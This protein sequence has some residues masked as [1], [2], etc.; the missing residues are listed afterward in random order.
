MLADDNDLA[1]N[2]EDKNILIAQAFGITDVDIITTVPTDINLEVV[3]DDDAGKF[4]LILAAISQMNENAGDTVSADSTSII[5]ALYADM[6]DGSIEGIDGVDLITA[7]N[8]FKNGTGANNE[9]DGTGANNTGGAESS[10]GEGSIMGDLAITKIDAYDG[11][12]SVPTVEDYINANVTGVADSNLL[13]INAHMI[14][15]DVSTTAK[16]QIRAD[17]GISTIDA[18]IAKISNY[19]G[20]NDT[21][22]LQDY[23]DASVSKVSETNIEHI[24]SEFAFLP[25]ADTNTTAKIQLIINDI[26]NA[27]FVIDTIANVSIAENT[28]FT[29]IAPTTS[30]DKPIGLLTY[31]LTGDDA[32]FVTIDALTGIVSMAGRNFEHP[33]DINEDNIYEF[34]I[35]LTDVEGNTASERQTITVTNLD[36]S[37]SFK[38]NSIANIPIAE[39][40]QFSGSTPSIAG[41]FIGSIVYSLSG[42]DAALFTINTE[43][44]VIAMTA[45]DFETPMDANKDNNYEVLII[46]IDL[47]GNTDS[48]EQIIT[49]LNAD[50]DH[51]AINPIDNVIIAENEVF[52][53]LAPSLISTYSSIGFETYSLS[54]VDMADFTIKPLTGIVSMVGRNFEEPGDDNQDNVYEIV[55]VVTDSEDNT[56]S[57]SQTITVTDVVETANFTVNPIDNATVA[58]NATFTGISPSISGVYIGRVNYSLVGVD[59]GAFTIDSTTGIVTMDV[60][61]FENPKDANADNVYQISIVATDVDGNTDDED[62]TITVTDVIEQAVFSMLPIADDSLT[63]NYQFN[64]ERPFLTGDTPIGDIVYSLGGEDADDFTIDTTTGMITM[65]TMDF[66]NP[67]DFDTDNIYKVIIIATDEDGNIASESQLITITNFNENTIV[68]DN[69]NF[70]IDENS[71][72]DTVVGT[73]QTTGEPTSFSI[74]ED[75][76]GGVFAID[77]NGLIT[78]V[79]SSKINYENNIYFALKVEITKIDADSKIADIGINVLDLIEI[80]NFNIDTIA[81]VIIPAEANFTG[82]VP[83]LSGDTPIGVLNYTLEGADAT[84]FIIDPLSGVVSKIAPDF[85]NPTDANNNNVYEITITLTD[86]DG[87]TYSENQ[88]IEITLSSVNIGTQTWSNHNIRAI[89][90]TS[91]TLNIDYWDAYA[92]NAGPGNDLDN[93]G[94]FY[95]YDAAMNVC[96]SGWHLP[97]DDDWK[98]LEGFLGM[99]IAEQDTQNWRGSD[100]GTQLKINGTS[101]FNARMTGLTG[102]DNTFSGRGDVAYFWT[103]TESDAGSENNADA[104]NAYRRNIIPSEPRIYRDILL[105]S[106]GLSVRCVQ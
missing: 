4:G 31:A 25:T 49:I 74:I 16:I 86:S 106:F 80:A 62:Q 42:A 44:G 63:E 3:K 53:G 23:I 69:Q 91:N 84:A 85:Y 94:Y 38:I 1:E 95:T 67:T 28:I 12:N 46:A 77:N 13:T 19:D 11:E 2:I 87:N 47:D 52:T 36:E 17:L 83:N 20:A 22:T 41:D 90:T 60:H 99:S 73:I 27:D 50:D 56:A 9:S 81:D 93:D 82:V 29:G 96:P 18:A 51:I 102:S 55:I 37:A 59:A 76:S 97:S 14:N 34:A 32:D 30:G 8:N 35:V 45:Q 5:D 103:S 58:E 7:I 64:G 105:K 70:D 65:I 88:K 79:D 15:Y 72:N 33:D 39:N 101:G 75:G 48:E 104:N 61:N 43:S 54:G 92:G 40:T 78:V 68:M 71:P 98:T 10:T 6:A 100:E 21:P 66:E 57:Q 26:L 89:P 24:N